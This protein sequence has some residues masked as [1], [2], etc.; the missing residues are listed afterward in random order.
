MNLRKAIPFF[1]LLATLGCSVVTEYRTARAFREER[2]EDAA[3][4]LKERSKLDPENPAILRDLGWA[5]LET[6]RYDQAILRLKEAERLSPGDRSLP[7]LLGLAYE[8]R[9]Q[10]QKAI[11]SYHAYP[12]SRGGAPAARA[13]RGRMSRLVRRVYAE[14]AASV[15]DR[16]SEISEGLL[17]IRYFEVLAETETYGALGKGIA[18]QLANDFSRVEGLRVVPRL[19]YEAVKAEAE[20]AR[21]E[22]FD[23]LAVS[24]VDAMLGAQWS[25][26]GTVLPR[27]EENEIRIDYFLVNNETGETLAPSSVSGALNEFFE[28]EKRIAF[29]VLGRLGIVPTITERQGIAIIPTTNFKAYLAY[30]DALEAEDRDE[31]I[32]A[33][34]LFERAV[35]LDP[36]FVLAAERGERTRGSREMIR[37]IV[38]AEIARPDDERRTRRMDRT[39]AMLLPAPLPEAGEGSDLSNVRAFGSAALTV[40]VEQP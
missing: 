26:G 24:S 15:V 18:E 17:A 2:W 21:T 32:R 9:E 33:R 37:S 36:D 28:L 1:F 8:G 10:W 38:A 12:G 3:G 13:V 4:I 19:S 20:A 30:C 14:W 25:L 35:L 16:P 31:H 39:S 23:P 7:L 27:E 34:G 22:G 40:R 11:D 6:G 5:L 29:D